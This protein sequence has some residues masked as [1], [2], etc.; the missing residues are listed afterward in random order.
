[1]G[2]VC[3]PHRNRR[4]GAVLCAIF[5]PSLGGMGPSWCRPS[6]LFCSP[7][8]GPRVWDQLTCLRM[9]PPVAS[10]GGISGPGCLQ[11]L[12]CC[13][14]PTGVRDPTHPAAFWRQ[15]CSAP[16]RGFLHSQRRGPQGPSWVLA[17]WVGTTCSDPDGTRACPLAAAAQHLSRGSGCQQPPLAP[18]WTV[19]KKEH[20]VVQSAFQNFASH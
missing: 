8:G 9:S 20:W 5:Q 6:S 11:T 4:C 16:P 17:C 18:F 15:A 10:A 13:S 1:M 3:W 19:G 7:H 14:A 2:V 12:S